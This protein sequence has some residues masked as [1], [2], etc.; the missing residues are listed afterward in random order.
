MLKDLKLYG[1]KSLWVLGM[2][3]WLNVR[4]LNNSV[5]KYIFFTCEVWLENIYD[6]Q[7]ANRFTE[8]LLE[9][10]LWVLGMVERSGFEQLRLQIFFSQVWLEMCE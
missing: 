3:A 9:R 1:D 7:V 6:V 8:G 4:E 5:R 2:V 10:N